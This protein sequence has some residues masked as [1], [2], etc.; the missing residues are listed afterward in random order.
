MS[1]SE[2]PL[3]SKELILESCAGQHSVAHPVLWA[4]GELAQAHRTLR[5][6]TGPRGEIAIRR[7]GLI[8]HIDR[9]LATELPTAHGGA[10]MHTESIGAVVDRLARYS[11]LARAALSE[12][13]TEPERHR[14]WHR[15]SE[16]ALG[17]RDLAFEVAAGLRRL[18]DLGDPELTEPR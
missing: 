6:S 8:R 13:A 15:L 1:A 7:A 9:W 17:Y 16:L 10:H 4:A 5:V 11:V 14:A 2:D 3:P 12:G 18:P